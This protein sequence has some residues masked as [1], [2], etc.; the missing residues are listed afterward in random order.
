MIGSTDK[1]G[2]YAVAR[3]AHFQDVLATAYHALGIDPHTFVKDMTDRPVP[4]L[5]SQAEPIGELI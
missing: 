3:P 5:P 4:L 1:L 2:A